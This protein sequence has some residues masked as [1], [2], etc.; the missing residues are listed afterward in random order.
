VIAAVASFAACDGPQVTEP[1]PY[2]DVVIDL[3]GVYKGLVRFYAVPTKCLEKR[4]YCPAALNLLQIDSLTRVTVLELSKWEQR[5][6][7]EYEPVFEGEL[8]IDMRGC[9]WAR[10]TTCRL[11]TLV[12]SVPFAG[13]IRL[14]PEKVLM[15]AEGDHPSRTSGRFSSDLFGSYGGIFFAR[16]ELPSDEMC[17]SEADYWLELAGQL[18]HFPV[19]GQMTIMAHEVDGCFGRIP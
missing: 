3:S 15:F 7:N 9:Y 12:D 8:T 6:W 17:E 11:P 4:F 10:P 2:P 19:E 16:Q 14:L 18:Q 1:E 13:D 5:E